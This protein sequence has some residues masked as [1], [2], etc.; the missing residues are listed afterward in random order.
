MNA[1]LKP[2]VKF[3]A[4][5]ILIAIGFYLMLISTMGPEFTI[6]WQGKVDFLIRMALLVSGFTLIL[7]ALVWLIWSLLKL[8]INRINN[9]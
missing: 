4:A 9:Q 3:I 2:I 8:I 6:L 5:A 1:K 7:G